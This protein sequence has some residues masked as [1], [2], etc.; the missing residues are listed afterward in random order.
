[1]ND[2]WIKLYRKFSDWEWYNIS[3]MV[4]LFIHL[5]INANHEKGEWRG[6]IIERG[7]ILTGL[8]S[9][10]Q[11][12]KISFQTLRTCLKRLEKTGEINIQTTNQYSIITI[13]KYDDYQEYQ[14]TTNKQS[15]KQLTSDQQ[16]TNKQL[17]T[18]KNEKNN[19]EEKE[20]K[21][22][23]FEFSQLSLNIIKEMHSFFRVNELNNYKTFIDIQSFVSVM[24]ERNQTDYLKKQFDAYKKLKPDGKFL[25]GIYKWMG[26][27]KDDIPWSGIWC[28]QTFEPAKEKI[29]SI[30][31]RIAEMKK[32]PSKYNQNGRT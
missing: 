18:N 16:T 9:L 21:E 32:I 2:G 12:T 26:S 6:V 3:E 20:E 1:M 11:K 5:L 30:E 27:P 13:L 29:L 15:N 19:K 23:P 22:Y 24:Q 14:Q 28:Q 4:H 8:N 17:T 31:E 10:N 25:H 7:Q